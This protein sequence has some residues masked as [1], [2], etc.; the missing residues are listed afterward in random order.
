M[1]WL[2]VGATLINRD[3]ILYVRFDLPPTGEDPDAIEPSVELVLGG[4]GAGAEGVLSFRGDDALALR[5]Y[6]VRLGDV[7]VLRPV[8][9]PEGE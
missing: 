8:P 6:F 4:R 2:Q 3:S 7:E 5:E 1:P 9:L